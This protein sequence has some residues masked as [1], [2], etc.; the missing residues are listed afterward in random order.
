[1]I[2]FLKDGNRYRLLGDGRAFRGYELRSF[3]DDAVYDLGG[4]QAFRAASPEAR[5]DAIRGAFPRLSTSLGFTQKHI[6]DAKRDRDDLTREVNRVL[7]NPSQE[8][9]SP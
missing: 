1:M 4:W 7:Y 9:P 2:E 3:L 6:R 5:A 8:T